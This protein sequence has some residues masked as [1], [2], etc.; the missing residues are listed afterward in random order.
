MSQQ[1][2]FIV[3]VL[4]VLLLTF[5]ERFLCQ[6]DAFLISFS[7]A[8]FGLSSFLV[9]VDESQDQPSLFPIPRKL[10]KIWGFLSR[11]AYLL[12]G[13]HRTLALLCIAR[14]PAPVLLVLEILSGH[15][16]TQRQCSQRMTKK[17]FSSSKLEYQLLSIPYHLP[18]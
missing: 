8:F 10:Q 11:A 18:L 4:R 1:V 6:V 2:Y 13:K 12:G 17:Q 15:G 14:T 9:A 3:S 5:R 7:Q 16:S